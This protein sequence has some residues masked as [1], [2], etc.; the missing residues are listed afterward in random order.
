MY[1][2]QIESECQGNGLEMEF[3]ILGLS[4][5]AINV[6]SNLLSTGENAGEIR[7]ENFASIENFYDD[8]NTEQHA[9]TRLQQIRYF[10][11]KD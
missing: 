3:Q 9:R 6:E 10:K 7:F 8:N 5:S 11:G 1:K 4:A 2:M